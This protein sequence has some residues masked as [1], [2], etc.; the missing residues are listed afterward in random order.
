MNTPSL[1]AHTLNIRTWARLTLLISA[2]AMSG[3]SLCQ[4]PFDTRAHSDLDQVI[5]LCA[6]D[7]GSARFDQAWLQWLDANPDADV[8][9]A[10]GTV[11]SRSGTLRSMALPGMQPAPRGRKP[12]PDAIA[13][14]MLSLARRSQT[15]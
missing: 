2:L 4:T 7:P 14:R 1:P 13:E 15:R 8:D 12:D 6:T 5:M 10:V 3:I 9:S 11:I